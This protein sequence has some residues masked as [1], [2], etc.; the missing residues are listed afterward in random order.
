MLKMWCDVIIKAN[1][2][3]QRSTY[4]Y[5]I[6]PKTWVIWIAPHI[7]FFK[8]SK[9]TYHL[10]NHIAPKVKWINL[11]HIWFVQ[12]YPNIMIH[13]SDIWKNSILAIYFARRQKS[14]KSICTTIVFLII[15]VFTFNDPYLRFINVF[16]YNIPNYYTFSLYQRHFLLVKLKY[17]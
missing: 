15:F 7:F 5:V 1:I 8:L 12:I 10:L 14:P 3:Q 9:I 16:S 17:K 13:H 6:M 4:L 11:S 2:Y